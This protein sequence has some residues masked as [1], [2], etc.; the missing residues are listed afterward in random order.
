MH[1]KKHIKAFNKL[2]VLLMVLCTSLLNVGCGSKSNAEALATYAE[3]QFMAN[4]YANYISKLREACGLEDLEFTTNI[5]YMYEYDY[6]KDSKT[7]YVECRPSFTSDSIDDYYTTEYNK[8]SSNELAKVLKNL[9]E[10]YY[11]ETTFTYSS[12]KGTVNLKIT[13]GVSKKFHILTSSGRDYEFSYYVNYDEVKIDDEWV[14]M[15]KARDTEYASSSDSNYSGTFDAKLKYGSGSVLIC[16]SEDAMD[17]YMTALNNGNQGTID[18]MTANGEIAF[19]EQN[20]KC[21]IVDKKI[22]KAKVNL[23]D[24]SYAGNTVWVI[25]E[26]LQEE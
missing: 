7:L 10:A 14:Y 3:E 15:V 12:T 2:A 20:T 6:D 22:T 19:T 23:L 11:E 26:S 25:I 17:R 13:N 5:Y 18:E 1:L 8:T 21:N 9:K 16:I 24:G 4:D